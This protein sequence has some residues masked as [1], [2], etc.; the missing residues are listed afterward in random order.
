TQ[1]QV[2]RS[3]SSCLLGTLETVGARGSGPRR[4]IGRSQASPLPPD[5][6][7]PRLRPALGEP[8]FGELRVHLDLD[9]LERFDLPAV[10]KRVA[11]PP[12][13]HPP[14]PLRPRFLVAET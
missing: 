11:H 14:R 1:T 8:D 2:L 5:D 4:H 9:R 3:N 13:R 6:G 10:G 7:E 12:P